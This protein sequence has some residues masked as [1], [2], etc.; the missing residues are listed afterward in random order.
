MDFQEPKYYHWKW[1][2][3]TSP[4][5]AMLCVELCFFVS[6]LSW[7]FNLIFHGK[8]NVHSKNIVSTLN[9]EEYWREDF[10]HY[11]S[12]MSWTQLSC[13]TVC[14]EGAMRWKGKEAGWDW[15][16]SFFDSNK[17]WAAVKLI[18]SP[19]RGYFAT[20][21]DLERWIILH[22]APGFLQTPG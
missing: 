1:G 20:C 15:E 10:P 18:S 22:L 13:T 5:T 16:E 2:D 6:S 11:L 3:N 17:N 8:S 19:V 21:E 4:S 7:T 9:G 14:F 12:E